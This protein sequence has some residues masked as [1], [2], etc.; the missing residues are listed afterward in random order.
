M[1][2]Q[3]VTTWGLFDMAASCFD[4]FWSWSTILKC[5]Y[6]FKDISFLN[7]QH[8][9]SLILGKVS[10]AGTLWVSISSRLW[11]WCCTLLRSGGVV[12]MRRKSK[13]NTIPPNIQFLRHST[14]T[15]FHKKIMNRFP[16]LWMNKF[17]MRFSSGIAVYFNRFGLGQKK[18]S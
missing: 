1:S 14:M 2:N 7:F 9:H 6:F 3:K 16:G 17:C 15:S 5:Q 13:A 11:T 4:P 10:F 12:D 18:L 8:V